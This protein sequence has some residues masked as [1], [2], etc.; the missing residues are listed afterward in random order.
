MKLDELFEI[1][2]TI[3]DKIHTNRKSIRVAIK[4]NRVYQNELEKTKRSISTIVSSEMKDGNSIYR[5]CI[6]NFGKIDWRFHA[7]YHRFFRRNN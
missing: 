3:Q 1:Y 2:K 5:I 7:L 6:E 4:E